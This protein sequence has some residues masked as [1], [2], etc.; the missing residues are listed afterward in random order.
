MTR[1]LAAILLLATALSGLASPQST[2]ATAPTLED[3]LLWMN[4]FSRDHGFRYDGGR[5]R[6]SNFFSSKGCWASFEVRFPGTKISKTSIWKKTVD[7]KLEDLNPRVTLETNE[8]ENTVE[9]Y[10]ER[11]DAQMKIHETL[12]YGDGS[13]LDAWV[14]SDT[15]YFDAR[16]SAI[17]FAR[18]LS[19][20]I[21][22][23]T[24]NQNGLRER[25][26]PN[27]ANSLETCSS[28]CYKSCVLP[29]THGVAA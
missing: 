8:K 11:L 1:A 13:K 7:A 12:R 9:V 2:P 4:R 28:Q 25:S 23:C 24:E 19:Q 22:F 26:L 17:R 20:A 29:E 3:T 10:F 16:G 18:A 6:Q 15:L 21:T 27:P 14:P 5:V